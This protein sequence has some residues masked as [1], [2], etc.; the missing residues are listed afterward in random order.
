MPKRVGSE[1]LQGAKPASIGG[2][3]SSTEQIVEH[4]EIGLQT[5]CLPISLLRINIHTGFNEIS[6]ANTIGIVIIQAKSLMVMVIKP[7]KPRELTVVTAVVKAVCHLVKYLVLRINA[8]YRPKLADDLGVPTM[9][10]GHEWHDVP[11][12]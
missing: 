1:R 9:L 5:N 2:N 7:K 12:I 10:E 3:K 4:I 11:L 6:P 8:N